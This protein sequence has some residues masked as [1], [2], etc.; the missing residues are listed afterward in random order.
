MGRDQRGAAGRSRRRTQERLEPRRR[1]DLVPAQ[2][3]PPRQVVVDGVLIAAA[4]WLAFFLTFDQTVPPLLPAPHVV[5][6]LRGRRRDRSSSCSRCSASTTAGGATSRP[7]T[8]GAL[9]RGVTVAC[10][11]STLVLYAFPP[12]STSHLPKRIVAL[13]YLLLL[14]FVAGTRLLAR[15]LVERPGGGIVARGKEVL[16]V[17]A[18]DAGQLLVR[19][20]QRNR[21]LA[22]TPGR[23]RRRRPAQARQPHPRRSRARD[24]RRPR[25]IL[26]RDHRPDEVLIAMPSAPGELRRKIVETARAG[27]HRRQDAAGAARADRGRPRPRRPGPPG[28]GRGRARPRAG[29]GRPAGD[30]RLHQGPGRARDRRRRLDR[31][32]A[33]PPGRPA[34][35]QAARRSSRRPSRRSTRSSASSSTSAT[36]PRCSRCSPTAATRRRCATR[37][38]S[39]SRRSCFHAAAYK[40]VPMLETNPM[41][42]VTNNILATQGDRAGLDRVRRRPLRL[43]LD[44]QGGQAEEPARPV[45]GGVR[46]DRRVVRAPRR[47][48]DPVR[49]GALR[50][51]AR[52]V[53]LGDP[54]L[55][56][57]DRA[58]RA[59]DG[60]ERRDDAVLHDD[61]RGRLARD[62]GRRDGWEAARS[63]CST[64]ASRSRSSTSPGR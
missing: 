38:R 29:R 39:T 2:P 63:T 23:F 8:C 48:L 19:E 5:G 14:A 55:P 57:P 34:R 37:S 20:M 10:V 6:G 62:P 3:A 17:G 24:D 22:F 45:E 61:P 30:R 64:W 51:R 25:H 4:W 54:D 7:T 59:G 58:R 47:R 31:L 28:S 13:D 9:L 33:L 53:G 50:E 35:R 44:R 56:P 43:H 1:R 18:G 49:R 16:V 40:H 36:S 32:R 15:S 41:Q 11:V 60:D 27:G 21:L 52:L 12:A 42:A 46:V 26:I